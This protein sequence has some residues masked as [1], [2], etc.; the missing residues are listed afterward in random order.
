[1]VCLSGT[2]DRRTG[3]DCSG[4]GVKEQRQEQEFL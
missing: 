1:M 3:E 4:Q 2:E